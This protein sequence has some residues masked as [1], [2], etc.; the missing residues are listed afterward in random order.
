[1]AEQNVVDPKVAL[2]IPAVPT[3]SSDIDEVNK[4]T[5]DDA[6]PEVPA[7]KKEKS[8]KNTSFARTR[9]QSTMEREEKL[10][11]QKKS[12]RTVTPPKD[13]S[14]TNVRAYLFN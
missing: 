12:P 5:S 8:S 2:N 9:K 4:I 1:M 3:I 11:A 10:P 14:S 6:E 7:S 13:K